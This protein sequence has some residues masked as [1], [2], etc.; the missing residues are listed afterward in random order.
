MAVKNQVLVE[1]APKVTPTKIELLD[2]ETPAAEIK[3]ISPERTGYQRQLGKRM[4]L[5]QISGLRLSEEALLGFTLVQ[6]DFLPTIFFSFIDSTKNFT[7][8]SF[9]VITPI[10]S[11]YIAPTNKMLKSIS[12]DYLITSIRSMVLPNGAIRYDYSGEL[13]V[14]RLNSNKSIAYRSMTSVEAMRAI[15]KDLGLGFAT[16]ED[17]T[18]DSMTWINPNLNYKTFIQK[19]AERAYKS[20]KS[21]FQAFID[22]NYVL[23]FIN[24]E[25]QY[26]RDKEADVTY[27]G[28]NTK[29]NFDYQRFENTDANDEL[30]EVP[31]VLTNSKSSQTDDMKI[32][33]YS[34]ISE[35]GDILRT[36]SFRKRVKW[37]RH[38]DQKLDFFVEPISDLKPEDGK[39]HQTPSLVDFTGEDVVKWIGIDYDNAHDNYKFARVINMHNEKELSKNQLK[40]VLN[41]A[42]FSVPRGSRVK[43]IIVKERTEKLASSV[44]LNAEIADDTT[45]FSEDSTS[46]HI[47]KSLSDFYYV[48][49]VVVRYR[50]GNS[51]KP[52]FTTEMILSKRNWL[53]ERE[54]LVTPTV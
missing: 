45:T 17:Q 2:L 22:R 31:M 27:L 6:N 25:R 35:N 33:E 53:P 19:I 43:V 23:N 40:V 13:Y 26:S 3:Q 28:L 24:V 50:K 49:D 14:P 39:V 44:Q 12:G 11:I 30:Y 48:K 36:E 8:D 15:A 18:S 16:N 51:P 37:Y 47:D 42:N 10:A 54:K 7:F 38:N 4:P 46:E 29:Q 41:G 20:E 32:L 9:P 5:I 21:F 1:F 52:D 34:P